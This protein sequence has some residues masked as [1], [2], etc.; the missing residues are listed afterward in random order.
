MNK[1]RFHDYGTQAV[2][3]RKKRILV[4]K[5]I[6]ILFPFLILGAAEGLLRV[7]HYGHNLSLFIPAPGKEDTY[8]VL[9][10]SAS[11]KYFSNE[12]IATTGNR[13]LFKKVKDSGAIRIFVL[14]ESTTIGYP[15]FH[16]GSFHRWLQYRLWHNYPNRRFE[17][18]NI[19]LTGVNSYTIAGFAKDI[20]PYQPDAVLIYTGH[21][22]YYG[23]L[24]AGS[25]DK[26]A[27]S[28]WVID[29]VLKLREL[30]LTQLMGNLIR[31]I[32]VPGTP[33][34]GDGKTRME[35]MVANQQIPINSEI[36]KRG[37][38]Q[39]NDNMSKALSLL[40]KA[41]VPVF[42]GNLVSS[43]Y[44]LFPFI[45]VP[46]DPVKY[47]GFEKQYQEGQAA[48]W[49]GDS[50]AAQQHFLAANGIFGEHAGCNYYLGLLSLQAR[51]SV[52]GKSYFD[53]ARD[54]DVLRFRAPS[55]INDV[56]A[57]LCT[58]Y[59]NSH[60]VDIKSVFEVHSLAH[61]IGNSLVLE[62][63]HPNLKGYSLMS[64]A[65]YQALKQEGILPPATEEAMSYN[66]MTAGMPLTGVDSLAGAYKIANLKRAWP[67]NQ[68]NKSDTTIISSRE[69]QL[70]YAVAFRH[71]SWAEA[72]KELYTA[73]TRAQD[74]EAAGKIMEALAL[75]NQTEPS[76]LDEA[77]NL[78]G[79]ANNIPEALVCFK[80]SF[81]LAPDFEKARMIFVL[82][83]QLDRPEDAL[84]YLDYAIANNQ[85]QMNLQP[86]RNYLL[87]VM[88]LK[89]AM[90]K[91]PGNLHLL[92]KIAD[93]YYKMGNTVGAQHYVEKILQVEPRNIE[94]LTL[95]NQLKKT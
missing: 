69:E 68:G 63:V 92:N 64:D 35:L 12:Q 81:L 8:Y 19:S 15:Y 88:A 33:A 28:P 62:H 44:D 6:S 43:E 21:N 50:T 41:G 80:R 73:Y 65:F 13:E 37:I 78:F 38:R 82:A 45:S 22:E 71:T 90:Q 10:P 75:E 89:Q 60:L 40:D 42:I 54:F 59:K 51:D 70:A 18:I 24:G 11:L 5:I 52:A 16:N 94:A 31:K 53:N 46:V 95:S 66:S 34:A 79:Q 25:T 57:Q 36:Y 86:V 74:W 49:K 48:L 91:E 30:R 77:G 56:I 1:T 17:I 20:L 85:R 26:I 67:F 23:C 7:F 93:A 4:I 84:P 14:G 76:Y 61:I 47:P 83:L 32:G 87:E 9:N 39:F 55:R 58:R 3:L 2:L 29:L 72:M 27:G